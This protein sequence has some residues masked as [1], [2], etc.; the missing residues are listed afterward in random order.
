M[1]LKWE[2]PHSSPEIS[3]YLNLERKNT[4]PEDNLPIAGNYLYAF[5]YLPNFIA[6]EVRGAIISYPIDYCG[7]EYLGMFWEKEL[8]KEA[9]LICRCEGKG[10]P[11]WTNYTEIERSVGLFQI[12]MLAHKEYTEEWLKIPENNNK[13]AIKIYNEG[14]GWREWLNCARW[15][16]VIR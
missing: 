11:E 6:T 12:N 10:H 8:V 4:I 3:L 13:A 1:A 5:S 9:G 2:I 7:E 15:T 14:K 16:G